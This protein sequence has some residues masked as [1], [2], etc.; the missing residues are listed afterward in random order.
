MPEQVRR[1]KSE[2]HKTP[3]L[4]ASANEHGW[5]VGIFRM[6]GIWCQQKDIEI[7]IGFLISY[8]SVAF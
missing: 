4:S 6:L 2:A 1:G 8:L 3:Q 7:L 5:S